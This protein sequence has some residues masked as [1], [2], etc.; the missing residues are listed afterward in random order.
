MNKKKLFTLNR[1]L[2]RDIGYLS[3]GFTIIFA[4][5][6]LALNHR[7]DW[8][9]NYNITRVAKSVKL[10]APTDEDILREAKTLF[11]IQTTLKGSFWV[12]PNELKMFFPH[13]TTVIYFKDKNEFLYE[14][15]KPRFLL[16][17]FN[18]LHVNEL[19]S[20]WIV[21]S[22]I[23]SVFLLY[24][25]LSALFMVKGRKGIL[26]RGGILAIIGIIIPAIFFFQVF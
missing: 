22:D 11:G 25:A 24:L 7:D 18:G 4:L 17:G 2:H 1:S 10:E 21:A 9:P 20:Y 26:G 15:I 16:R 12:N 14:D 23:Y 13:E 8:N 3:I 19:K 5:S 6:G